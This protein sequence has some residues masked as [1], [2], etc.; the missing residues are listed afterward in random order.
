MS[1]ISHWSR[2]RGDEDEDEDEDDEGDEDGSGESGAGVVRDRPWTLGRGEAG[3][4][5]AEEEGDLDSSCTVV[6]SMAEG[7]M[8]R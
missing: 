5:G 8:R 7:V 3:A 2:E 1:L 4:E 6:A